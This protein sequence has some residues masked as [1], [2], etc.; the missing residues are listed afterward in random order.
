MKKLLI[1]LVLFGAL[2]YGL[3]IYLQKAGKASSGNA[4]VANEVLEAQ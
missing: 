3:Q 2:A 1:A 4:G